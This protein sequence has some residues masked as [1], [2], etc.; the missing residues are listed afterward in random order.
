LESG[1]ARAW[2]FEQIE[3][4]GKPAVESVQQTYR[5][6]FRHFIDMRA[7][8]HDVEDEKIIQELFCANVCFVVETKTRFFKLYGW[9][10]GVSEA[11]G[12]GMNHANPDEVGAWVL[13]LSSREDDLETQLPYTLDAGDYASTKALV[14]G[15]LI[16]TA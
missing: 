3:G 15:L 14:E 8:S 7:F 6:L 11:G 9:D 16:P 13:N 1:G 12:S 4:S 10:A 2:V 5:R